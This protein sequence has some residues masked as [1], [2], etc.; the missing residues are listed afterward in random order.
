MKSHKTFDG[1]NVLVY[2]PI[3]HIAAGLH[4]VRRRYS[5]QKCYTGGQNLTNVSTMTQYHMMLLSSI[6]FHEVKG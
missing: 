5:G 3:F 6:E 1:L 4:H 2:K